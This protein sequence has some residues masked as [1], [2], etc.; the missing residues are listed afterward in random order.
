MQVFS[1]RGRRK[2]Y[3]VSF[4]IQVFLSTFLVLQWDGFVFAESVRNLLHGVTPYEFIGSPPPYAYHTLETPSWYAYPPL[5]LLMMTASYGPLFFLFGSNPIVERVF[6]AMPSILGNLLCAHLVYKLVAGV[7]SQESASRAEKLILYNPFLILIAAARGMFDIWMINFLLLCLLSLR[8]E[9]Y[10]RSGLYFGLGLL[11]KPILAVFLP[12][13]LVYIWNKSRSITVPV[14]FLGWAVMTFAI[15]CLPFFF[16]DPDG[17]AHQIAGMHW[18]RPPGG[19]TLASLFS[20]LPSCL[21]SQVFASVITVVFS[22]LLGTAILM[23]ALYFRIKRTDQENNL[24]AA[25]FLAILLFTLLNKVANPQYFVTVVVLAIVLLYTYRTYEWFSRVDVRRYYKWL[26][27]PFVCATILKD[28]PYNGLLPYD[29]A[30]KLMHMTG[31]QLELLIVNRMPFSPGS[32]D[33]LLG[34]GCGLLAA[35]AVILAMSISYRAIRQMI[36]TIS[37]HVCTRVAEAWPTIGKTAIVR[38]MN[39]SLAGLLV[40]IPL[41]TGWMSYRN[42]VAD[43]VVPPALLE[44]KLVGVFYH[45]WWHNSSY[46]PDI[47]SDNWLSSTLTPAE[48]YYDLNPAYMGEDI[49]LMKQAQ[50]DFAVV[51]FGNIYPERYSMFVSACEQQSFYFVP[52]IEVYD[53]AIDQPSVD[54]GAMTLDADSRK[55]MV[56]KIDAAL[57]LKDSPCYLSYRGKPVLFIHAT[58]Y[59]PYDR[60]DQYP[61]AFWSEIQDEIELEHGEIFWV[62][63]CGF[64][65]QAAVLGDFDSLFLLPSQVWL[66]AENGEVAIGTW[67]DRT[68]SIS[69]LSAQP[70]IATVLPYYD[71]FEPDEDDRHE[72]PLV[73]AGKS[74]YDIFWEMALESDPDMLLIF[75]WNQYFAGACIEPTEEFGD[76]FLKQSRNWI[77]EFKSNDSN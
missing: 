63:N 11:I 55:K 43:E 51:S 66:N 77:N 54:D 24:V 50:I 7:S 71:G 19:Y 60:G 27:I 42:A 45:Y 10:Y 61:E 73:V 16:S 65:D 36:P 39:V 22:L 17:F 14:R 31:A 62:I 57:S 49:R 3:L 53:F 33:L 20:K 23:I 37:D 4:L 34:I 70:R 69:H 5:P 48:G 13:V 75:S 9:K 6:I 64:S 32:H 38:G 58:P 76:M 15:V 30:M 1:L 12:I 29:I 28:G 47:Q 67:K 18:A 52:M 2:H 41:S 35:P 74:T 68:A 46:D 59:F 8:Q 26:V 44:D 72:D 25:L 40:A 56:D 21:F